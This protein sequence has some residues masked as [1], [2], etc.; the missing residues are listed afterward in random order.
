MFRRGW[1]GCRTYE[2]SSYGFSLIGFA[3]LLIVFILFMVVRR[4]REYAV[5]KPAREVLFTVV[6]RKEIES[7]EFSRY[8]RLARGWRGNGVDCERSKVAWDGGCT[9]CVGAASLGYSVGMARVVVGQARGTK[10]LV[11]MREG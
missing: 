9:D 3:L 11:G 7:E 1:S 6:G 8:C 4:I 2:T 5:A 10:R